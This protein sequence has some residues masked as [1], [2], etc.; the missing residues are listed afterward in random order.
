MLIDD[1][2]P[3]YD[4]VEHHSMEIH[5]SP[6]AAYAALLSTDFGRSGVLRALLAL[7]SLPAAPR[8]PRPRTPLTLATIEAGGFARLAAVPP[9]EIVFGIEGRFWAL[10]GG[11]C[12]PPA[13]A[14]RVTAPAPGTARGVW[15]FTFTALDE[16]NTLASTE[17]RVLCAD[18]RTRRRF[19]PYWFLIR[20]GSGLIRRAML[21]QIRDAAQR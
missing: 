10:D 1:W 5:A 16:T 13:A 11:R 21:R 14:F 8:S 12:T 18:A 20:P 6:A 19:L 7:R 4:V 17:T 3:R 15:N 2:L 9:I